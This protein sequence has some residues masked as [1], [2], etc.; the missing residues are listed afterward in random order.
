MAIEVLSD[1]NAILGQCCCPM[2]ACP[3]PTMEGQYV[4]LNAEA[5]GYLDET[6]DAGP[7]LDRKI[8][9][10]QVN[11]STRD[12]FSPSNGEDYHSENHHSGEYRREYDLNYRHYPAGWPDGCPVPWSEPVESVTCSSSYSSTTRFY[13][14]DY[15]PG[16][17]QYVLSYEESILRSPHP[18][19][20]CWYID[21]KTATSYDWDFGPYPPVLEGTEITESESIAYLLTSGNWWVGIGGPPPGSTDT[22][23]YLNGVTVSEWY[24]NMAAII[25]PLLDFSDEACITNYNEGINS[26]LSINPE[27]LILWRFPAIFVTK[28]RFRWVIPDTWTDQNTGLPVTFPGSYFKITWD[29]ATYP[30]DPDAEISYIQDLTWEWTGP[31]DPEDEDSWKSGWYEID[32]PGEPGERKIVNVRYECYRSSRFGGKPQ[33]TGDAEDITDDVPLQLRLTSSR[34]SINLL[35]L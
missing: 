26:N 7:Y 2:P 19:E 22:E 25:I 28:S 3:E 24:S 23:Q 4:F 5:V 29:I 27:S 8:Y 13:S 6:E 33:I 21:T 32:P 11:T 20:N 10:E 12:W 1:W 34:H 35:H 14:L 31:G 16:G 30:T 15:I 17:S 9:K 18:T